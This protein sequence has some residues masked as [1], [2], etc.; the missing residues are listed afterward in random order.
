ME[1]KTCGRHAVE[2]L[3]ELHENIKLSE[4]LAALTVLSLCP[5]D[6]LLEKRLCQTNA[7]HIHPPEPRTAINDDSIHRQPTASDSIIV[8]ERSLYLHQS[9]LVLLCVSVVILTTKRQRDR[10]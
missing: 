9:R 5:L 3:F 1:N 10:E 6:C 4:L 2:R 7:R 8:I